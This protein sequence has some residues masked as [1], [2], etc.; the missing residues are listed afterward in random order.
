MAAFKVFIASFSECCV[1]N[2]DNRRSLSLAEV[3]WIWK[4]GSF[5]IVIIFFRF[6]C[7]AIDGI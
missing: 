2:H 5:R 3:V 4:G 7:W 1:A 6:R